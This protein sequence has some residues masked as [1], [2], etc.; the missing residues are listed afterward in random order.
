MRVGRRARSRTAPTAASANT[1]VGRRRPSRRA[2]SASACA[3]L[4]VDV[5]DVLQLHARLA[6]EVAGVDLA[7]PAGAEQRNFSHR[8]SPR[9]FVSS[10]FNSSRYA[11]A[12]NSAWQ[13]QMRAG[14]RAEREGASLLHR[15][16][17]ARVARERRQPAVRDHDRLRRARSLRVADAG[18]RLAAVGREADRDDDVVAAHRAR[19]ARDACR[20][21]PTTRCT[22]LPV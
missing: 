13:R 22:R 21:R 7:D 18:L 19:S 14:E 16:Q 17:R 5:D 12:T 4:G 10:T 9:S 15:Q 1:R 6:D 8:Q 2:A 11:S 3:A 20:R